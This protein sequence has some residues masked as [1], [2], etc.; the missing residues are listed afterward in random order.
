MTPRVAMSM[1]CGGALAEDMLGPAEEI[2]PPSS[3]L[4]V[5]GSI[6]ACIAGMI[7]TAA[8]LAWFPLAGL[9]TIGEG[10]SRVAWALPLDVV[11]AWSGV[12]LAA[13]GWRRL[14][15]TRF[16]RPARTMAGVAL[17]M[18]LIITAPLAIGLAVS[19][20]GKLTGV[21]TRR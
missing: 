2:V 10:G 21:M 15:A 5:G 3:R 18:A 16:V 9:A 7:V 4:A 1:A 14:R 8:S 20:F 6:V 12:A 13:F 17:A 19:F 11:A